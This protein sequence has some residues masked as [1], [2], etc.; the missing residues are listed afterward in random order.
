MYII[1]LEYASDHAVQISTAADKLGSAETATPHTA[2]PHAKGVVAAITPHLALSG[3][4]KLRQD[5]TERHP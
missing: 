2:T 5:L 1:E 4:L 3:V